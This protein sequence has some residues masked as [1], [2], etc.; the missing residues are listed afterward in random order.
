MTS[1]DPNKKQADTNSLTTQSTEKTIRTLVASARAAIA[2]HDSG[3]RPDPQLGLTALP[4]LPVEHPLAELSTVV[5]EMIDR[6]VSEV[7][8]DSPDASGAD[9]TV[10]L[11][12]THELL[13]R[14][15]FARQIMD[16]MTQGITV[17]DPNG[18]FIYANPSYAK[19]VGVP[20][21]DLIGR[22]LFDFSPDTESA[23]L[24]AALDQ[25][26]SGKSI[27]AERLLQR[28]D[29]K[30][31]HVVVSGAPRYWQ[32]EVVGVV[33]TLTDITDRK[34]IEA[35]LRQAKL[36][37]EAAS[38]AKSTFLANMSHEL[39]T[40]LNAIIGYSEL[41]S[42][43]AAEL[44]NPNFVADLD[45]I[46]K[47]GR[48]LLSLIND[49]LDLSKIEAG[50]MQI[51]QERFECAF[52]IK[53]VVQTIFPV[54][55]QNNNKLVVQWG[56]QQEIVEP[57]FD[58]LA[59][60][61][62]MVSDI[63]KVRQVLFNLLSNAAKFTQNGTIILRV[64]RHKGPIATAGTINLAQES[65]EWMSFQVQDSGIGMNPA[66]LARL[67]RPFDQG[68]ASIS[69]EYGGTG[70]GLAIS[71]RYCQLLGGDIGVESRPGVGS[72]FTV[73]LPILMPPP[74]AE[75]SAPTHTTEMGRLDPSKNLVLVVDDDPGSQE[76]IQRMLER[77]DFEVVVAADGAEGLALAKALR[78][79]IITLDIM[80]PGMNGWMVLASLKA[81]PDLADIPV[82]VITVADNDSAGIALGAS[83]YLIKPVDRGQLLQTV[84]QYARQTTSASPINPKGTVLVVEDD[85]HTRSLLDETLTR[86][87]WQVMTAENGQIALDLLPTMT[88]DLVLL[89]LLMPIMDGFEFLLALRKRVEWASIPVVVL[90]AKE[91]SQSERLLLGS[92]ANTLLN[93]GAF[94]QA[95]LINTVRTAIKDRP[96]PSDSGFPS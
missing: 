81:D 23:T 55:Q 21:G 54:I 30:M 87:H 4:R 88:P 34:E 57:D 15:G 66:K 67:F 90:T 25:Y 16:T 91:L 44:N 74:Q 58:A 85:P 51:F 75:S 53:E 52:L 63:T 6:L 33:S 14:Q 72:I 94:T 13:D 22:S 35:A 3:T 41:L 1:I 2:A 71:Q 11:P 19:M 76:L 73:Y 28:T 10:P 47:A 96:A 50:R 59:A 69:N 82:I 39:R 92:Q 38:K 17:S 29:G 64:A 45:K 46:R 62:T 93:K 12:G 24:R 42:E 31:L 56:P 43:D 70:L 65:D 68:D 27:L 80:M 61:G 60:L 77:E 49:I 78:P 18:I 95:D 79:D 48:H 26:L 5:A 36:A 9:L 89:D 84:S 8:A 83:D 86:D 37:A 40:P 20:E 32:G 7:S